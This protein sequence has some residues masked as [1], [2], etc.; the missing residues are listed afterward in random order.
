MTAT[1]GIG[2]FFFFYFNR[3]LVFLGLSGIILLVT[4][5]M[6]TPS[7]Y[8]RSLTFCAK[9]RRCWRGLLSW[10]K[11]GL[12]SPSVKSCSVS[13]GVSSSEPI[14]NLIGE[15]CSESDSIRT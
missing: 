10:S 2:F 11:E 12:E 4:F 1:A 8:N 3:F 7:F 6:S 14:Y 13:D 15:C 5:T 9:S